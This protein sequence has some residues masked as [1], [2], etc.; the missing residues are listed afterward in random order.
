MPF[1]IVIQGTF[2]EAGKFLLF[3]F[4]RIIEVSLQG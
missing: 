3:S 4:W 1:N 2:L